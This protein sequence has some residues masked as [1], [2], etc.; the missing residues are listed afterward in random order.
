MPTTYWNPNGQT[1]AMVSTLQVTA[2]ALNGTLTATINSKNITYTCTG[3]DTLTTAATNWLALLNAAS[4]PAEFGEIT[5]TSDGAVITAT[6]STPG[7]PFT[8]TKSEGGGATCTLT[9]VTANSSP[10]SAS[11][12]NNWLRS[13]VASL[14]QN[15]D[16]V[17][18]ANSAVPILWNLDAL[19]AVQF[20]SF[21]RWQSFTSTIGLPV[22]NPLGYVEYRPT[23]FQFTS[24]VPQ[25]PVT[26]GV[27][28]G[29]GPSRE[30]YNVGSVRTNLNVL[31][32]GS[33]ADQY[34][35]CFLGTHANNTV[36]VVATSVGIAMATG[37]VSTVDIATTD[38][39][40]TL[41]CGA[42]VTFSGTGGGGTY[43]LTG[44]A[45]TLFCTPAAVVARNSA[46]L[47]LSAA[48]GTYASVSAINGVQVTLTQPMTIT[49][50]TV[51]KSSNVDNS[52][53][54]GAVTITN[55]TIDGDTCQIND[56]NNSITYTN[57]AS[58]A[59][60]VTSGPFVFTG[61]RTVKVT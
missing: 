47:T 2:V 44:G 10:S 23:Y 12:L 60:Q 40:G 28:S 24:S 19:A 50:L 3:S 11:N 14:P 5:W 55:T 49:S 35:V 16:D 45:G 27:G 39:G 29:Q 1:I 46:I 30:R 17:V 22:L 41:D 43:T 34:A 42:G 32:S 25:L 48:N 58:V 59:G 31:A 9:A 26:L 52:Q 20:A 61:T 37:E 15:G 56:P 57:A 21:T 13:G 38:G 4:A 51:Q 7:T 36:K 33:A 18:V 6:A 53:N 8:L 54:L